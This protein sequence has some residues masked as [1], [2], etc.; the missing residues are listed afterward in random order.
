MTKLQVMASL[1][2]LHV[3]IVCIVL[4]LI[5]KAITHLS[6]AIM[7]T[8]LTL[9]FSLLSLFFV[10]WLT[11]GARLELFALMYVVYAGLNVVG[12]NALVN[13]V[14]GTRATETEG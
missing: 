1:I 9:P 13:Y 6:W 7:L 14:R 10:R 11:Q 8:A 12:V 4:A 5:L 3:V 2:Y